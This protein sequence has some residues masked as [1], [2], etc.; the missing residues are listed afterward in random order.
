M[1]KQV[2][3]G[4][5]LI[6]GDAPV[7]IQSMTSTDTR[8]VAKTLEQIGRLYAAGADIV[9]LA[10]A[11]M[12][13]AE[14]FCEIKKAAPVPLVTDIHFDYKI[15][16]ECIKGGADKVRINP[17]NIGDKERVRAVAQAAGAAG[18]P[19][20]IGVNMGSAEAQ[21]VE[22]YGLTPRA[23]VESAKYHAGLLEQ[24]GFTDIV[25]SLK[26]SDVKKTVEAY[27]IM[28][29]E[30]NYPLHV[31][32]TEAGTVYGGIIKSAAGI[33]S[34]L[35]DGIGDTI[36]VSLSAD[37]VEEIKAAKHLL[38]AVG[39]RKM[40]QLISCPTCGRCRINLFPI[41]EAVEKKLESV[42]VPI[43]VAVMGCAVNG[44]GEAREADVG[45]A[46]GDKKAVLFKKGE[47]IKSIPE[48]EILNVL[49][50]EIDNLT[51]EN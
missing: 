44:P 17:G 7:S 13:A 32:V 47:I 33:G 19:I 50:S 11:D 34:L 48:D 15:A 26:A 42:K 51:G 3:A 30:C 23:M 31:G 27:R 37:P 9:R 20:R 12:K 36:R 18:I 1:R 4:G 43:K 22:K 8:D 41:A 39:L 35:L 21:F 40:P 5:I 49:F 38:S 16:L 24:E 6:G 14:A 2:N 45:I 10:V 25:I 46:G 28:A 29:D